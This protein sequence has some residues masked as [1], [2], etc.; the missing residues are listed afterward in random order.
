MTKEV[1]SKIAVQ[2][3]QIYIHLLDLRN[4]YTQFNDSSRFAYEY[5]LALRDSGIITERERQ[6]L[7]I[8]TT[9]GAI[10]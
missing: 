4:G 5:T 6:I 9:V 2:Y 7:F 10:K 3:P 8:F 1:V